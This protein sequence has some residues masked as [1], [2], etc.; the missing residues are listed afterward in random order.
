MKFLTKRYYTKLIGKW[1]PKLLLGGAAYELQI[2]ELV[3]SS[4]G[5]ESSIYGE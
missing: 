1:I 3:I 5:Q 4:G 2:Q